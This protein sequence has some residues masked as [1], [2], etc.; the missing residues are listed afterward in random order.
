MTH[1][2]ERLI[3]RPWEEDDAEE[4][5]KYAK[6]PQVGPTAGWQPHTNVEYSRE[7]IRTVLT[8]PET[9]ALVLKSTGKVVGSIGLMIGY[10]S[11]LDLP[12][13]QGEIGYWIG[14][15]YWGQGLVPE[16]VRKLIQYGFTDLKLE[17]MWC[18]YFDGNTKSKRVQEK[19][20][21]K[22]HHTNENVYWKAMDD[23]RTEHITCLTKK[24]WLAI[25]KIDN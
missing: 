23:L 4:L 10:N 14:V 12:E 6:D 15:P 13:T 8:D 24:Q 9:Y 22:Y 1:E 20:G 25:N 7:I 18:G 16:A 21:F 3:L 19:S 5:Y 17:K 11:N 2:T